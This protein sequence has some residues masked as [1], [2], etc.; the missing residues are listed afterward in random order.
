MNDPTRARVSIVTFGCR[1]NQYESEMMRRVLLDERME[2]VDSNAE[3]YLLNACTVTALAERKARQAARRIRAMH[4]EARIVLVGCLADAV[5]RGLAQFAEADLLAGN[6]WKTHPE[7]L[8]AAARQGR[9]GLLPRGPA[10]S[11]DA[12]RAGAPA[13]RV[14][15]YLKVQDGCSHA[16]TYCRPT[17]VRGPSRSKS[18]DAAFAE[19]AALVAAGVPELVVT[20]VDLADYGGRDR[21]LP[22]LLLRLLELRNLRRVRLASLNIDGVSD[23]L[24]AAF[25]SDDRLCR[26]FHLPAQSGDDA[27]LAAMGR[28]YT[29]A[30]YRD[31]VARVRDAL[32]NATF[33]TDLIVGF[34]G[35]SDD[36]LERTCRLI[37][38]VR[39]SNLHVFRYSPRPGTPAAALAGVVPV[40]AERRRAERVADAW[41]PVRERLLDGRRGRVEDVL[42]EERT[43]RQHRGY[44]SDYIRVTFD[45]STARPVGVE[46]PVRITRTLPDGLE[47]VSE[48]RDD[49]DGTHPA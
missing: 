49:S 44:T 16:C 7:E 41:R 9:R 28:P 43:G 38:D 42:V 1:V 14:R 22:T 26:H 40:E 37:E 2:V 10:G 36:A 3:V 33:G 47:G 11:L 30:V 17:L 25:R 27:I 32:P 15:A 24:L 31:V 8:V 19:A 5:E 18:A 35:E 48:D 20:G 39:F 29:A 45:A 23:A 46:H 21:A 13:D 12:E 4:P 6:A 34:P